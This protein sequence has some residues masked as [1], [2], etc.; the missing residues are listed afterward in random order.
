ML[1][2]SRTSRRGT[3]SISQPRIALVV[4]RVLVCLVRLYLCISATVGAHHFRHHLCACIGGGGFIAASF[5]LQA[6]LRRATSTVCCQLC[7]VGY[8]A[9]LSFVGYPSAFILL[10][11][12]DFGTCVH[13]HPCKHRSVQVRTHTFTSRVYDMNVCA[14][15]LV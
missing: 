13:A 11:G 6:Q 7:C 2:Y 14:H 10:N 1:V 8:R 5:F 9:T 15:A 4:L 12:P 3:V